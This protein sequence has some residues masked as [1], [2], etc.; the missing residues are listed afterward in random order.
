MTLKTYTY[1]GEPNV[2][3][4]SSAL[5][6]ETTLSNGVKM[7][8]NQ[9]I[10]GPT[11]MI[12]S[13]TLP[14]FNYV[15]ITEFQRYYFCKPPIWVANNMWQI[16]TEEDFLMSHKDDIIN[17]YAIASRLEDKGWSMLIDDRIVTEQIQYGTPDIEITPLTVLSGLSEFDIQDETLPNYHYVLTGFSGSDSGSSEF[18]GMSDFAPQG[19]TLDSPFSP[20]THSYT[21][22][23]TDSNLQVGFGCAIGV[24]A[25]ISA[26]TLPNNGHF[27]ISRI[28]Y[29]PPKQV[30]ASDLLTAPFVMST[31]PSI[32][33]TVTSAVGDVGTYTFTLRQGG[34]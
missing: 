31:N 21:G 25:S 19:F 30:M 28:G 2:V 7:E 33:I 3:D 11:L 12:E 18:D 1:T 5:T 20:A 9:S 13:T 6:G 15:Y 22:V 27:V 14:T 24:M 16:D 34:S 10:T 29:M 23:V 8:G 26:V 4:K 32:E 17:H